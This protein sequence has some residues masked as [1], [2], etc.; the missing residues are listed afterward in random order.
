MGKIS[1]SNDRS[2]PLKQLL[3]AMPSY[4]IRADGTKEWYEN[5]RLHRL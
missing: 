3:E 4:V 5:G 2:V 1:D